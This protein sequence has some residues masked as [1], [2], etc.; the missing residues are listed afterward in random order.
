MLPDV[1]LFY[2]NGIEIVVMIVVTLYL[3]NQTRKGS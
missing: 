1:N 3:F 2:I